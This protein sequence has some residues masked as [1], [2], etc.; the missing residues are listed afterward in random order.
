MTV[1]LDVTPPESFM[2]GMAN[3]HHLTLLLSCFQ[4]VLCANH[5]LPGYSAY[6]LSPVKSLRCGWECLVPLGCLFC[7][8]GTLL[9]PLFVVLPSGSKGRVL[10][11]IHSSSGWMRGF[12]H[13]LPPMLPLVISLTDLHNPTAD[14]PTFCRF[15]MCATSV[16]SVVH[17]SW[18]FLSRHFESVQ[19]SSL[20]G[21]PRQL[22][23]IIDPTECH[24]RSYRPVPPSTECVPSTH[25]HRHQPHTPV[26]CPCIHVPCG[27]VWRP[28]SNKELA[29][30]FDLP[31]S[32]CS[33]LPNQHPSALPW[34][35]SPPGKLLHG[36][37]SIFLSHVLSGGENAMPYSGT[38]INKV[39]LGQ[40]TEAEI[41]GGDSGHLVDK[42]VL[43]RV[44]VIDDSGQ[45]VIKEAV[46]IDDPPVRTC[47]NLKVGLGQSTEA[48][49]GGVDSGQLAVK[50]VLGPALVIPPASLNLSSAPTNLHATELEVWNQQYA[51]SVRA[52]NAQTP[53]H[54]W[55]SQVWVLAYNNVQLQHY[56]ARF[57]KCPL[58]AFRGMLLACWRVNVR[59]DFLLYLSAEYGDVW[60]NPKT[61]SERASK[62]VLAGCECLWR[63]GLADWWEW[64]AGSR[65]FFW[66]WPPEHRLAARD[67]YPPFPQS[68]LPNY[69]RPQPPERDPV[70]KQQVK[71]KLATVRDK[72]YI[73]KGKVLSLTSYFGVP[74]GD[75]D[76]RLVYD[77]TKSKLNASLWAPNF[78]LPTVDTLTRGI[79]D[80][81]WLGD[82]DIG[83]MFLNFMLH[84][85]LQPYAGID[86]R[87]YFSKSGSQGHT[88]WERWV[89]CLMGL[90]PSPYNC[91]KALLLALEFVKGNRQDPRNPF[92]W[93]HII[94]NLPGTPDYDPQKPR[95]SKMLQDGLTLAALIVSYVDDMRIAAGSEHLCWE[96]MHAVS[97]KL[98]YLGIQVATRKTR[99]PSRQ[100]GPWSG[101]MVLTDDLGVGVRATQ[102]KWDKTKSQLTDTLRLIDL[103]QP[104]HRKTLESYRGSLVYLQ[105]TYPAITPYVK[106][107]HLT[108]DGWR[109]DRDEEGWRQPSSIRDDSGT[110]TGPPPDYV[111]PVPRFRED[112]IALLE[113]FDT[114]SPP[115]R[116]VRSK[117]IRLASYSFTDASGGGFGS[118]TL[119]GEDLQ[120]THGVWTT[121]GELSTSNFRELE[122][123]V[124]TLEQGV[125]EGTLLDSEV[126]IFTDNSTSEA[127]FWKGHSRSQLLNQL[128]LRLRQIEMSGRVRIQMVHIPGT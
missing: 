25:I 71:D 67:G 15:S 109:P 23:H 81:S 56:H 91:I 41:G 74:K 112:I 75:Q 110:Q 104:I 39:G 22:K 108:I 7:K 61:R 29:R 5:G 58:D 37:A 34:L 96:A 122:N 93:D 27:F 70:M 118:S 62:D 83:E 106:G 36:M 72:R 128:A 21:Y 59:K 66:R 4:L 121:A 90:K 79:D 9:F 84:P 28:L 102:D 14:F 82:I 54:L 32:V 94:L 50:E 88:L 19:V 26:L 111:R 48:E 6:M 95:L 31:S 77:A 47:G 52:D 92:R 69:K 11:F 10:L 53:I 127:V 13:H 85:T 64:K 114:P 124:L 33:C 24:I 120:Y 46:V 30:A 80:Q 35:A 116:Y 55:D 97:C 99:P 89:R 43:G 16:G 78:G 113:L 45:L 60:R 126:W 49:I 1:P 38:A 103:G 65:P 115:T 51:K 40:Y 63:A 86:L 123:L 107:F 125:N 100:P 12:V 2:F 117:Q 17:G 76:I 87:P 68:P 73:D 98:T 119:T 42:E 18:Y 20:S 101:A 44:L 3:V 57:A 8:L 105:R